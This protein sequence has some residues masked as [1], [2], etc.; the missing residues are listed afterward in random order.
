[1]F[2]VDKF[3]GKYKLIVIGYSIFSDYTTWLATITKH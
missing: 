3:H 1:L 2:I